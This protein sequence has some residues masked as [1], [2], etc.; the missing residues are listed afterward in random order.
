MR[1]TEVRTSRRHGVSRNLVIANL[2][3]AVLVAWI[4][5]RLVGPSF[6]GEFPVGYPLTAFHLQPLTPGTPP[7]RLD[8]LKGKVTVINYWA[9]W[10]GYC[11]DELPHLTTL[12]RGY[13]G[14]DDFRLLTVSTGHPDE[15]SLRDETAE[16]LRARPEIQLPVYF[17]PQ[18][19]TRAGFRD[20]PLELIPIT[21]VLDRGGKVVKVSPGFTL[22]KF[23]E[24]KL[25]IASLLQAKG[26]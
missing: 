19:A 11:V 14:R 17:D 6:R 18:D 21:V 22:Q 25:L 3:V 23:E 12:A 20:V 8:E 15:A 9:T 10:C 24:L 2:A 1:L 7:V 13:A 26:P 16:F 5:V 4:V